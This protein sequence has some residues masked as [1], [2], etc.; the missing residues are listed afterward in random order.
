[1]GLCAV[2]G[3]LDPW[4]V[5]VVA[6]TENHPTQAHCQVESGRGIFF[7]LVKGAQAEFIGGLGKKLQCEKY[8]QLKFSGSSE[9]QPI[10]HKA[11]V[12]Q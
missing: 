4:K 12:L 5:T 3:R 1:M 11:L 8:F 6:D 10:D 2:T 9:R 7:F